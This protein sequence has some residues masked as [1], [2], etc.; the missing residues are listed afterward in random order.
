MLD[1]WL[2]WLITLTKVGAESVKGQHSNL[3]VQI[4]KRI[5]L[6]LLSAVVLATGIAPIVRAET[7][8][9]VSAMPQVTPFNLVFLAYQGYF[10]AEGISSYGNLVADFNS[11]RVTAEDLVESAIIDNR[12]TEAARNDTGYVRSVEHQLRILRDNQ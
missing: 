9:Q 2:R 11:G 8:A 1:R 7:D 12:L 10:E 3:G 4:M 6:S 5:A